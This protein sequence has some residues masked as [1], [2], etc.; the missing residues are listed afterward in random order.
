MLKVKTDC[1]AYIEVASKLHQTGY[2]MDCLISTD[3]S[4]FSPH[5]CGLKATSC[6]VIRSGGMGEGGLIVK[7]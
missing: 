4:K 7:E 1:T 6:E 5:T 2:V 3:D